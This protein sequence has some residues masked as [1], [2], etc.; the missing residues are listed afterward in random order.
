MF[1]YIDLQRKNWFDFRVHGYEKHRSEKDQRSHQIRSTCGLNG[2]YVLIGGI[3]RLTSG[4]RRDY[5]IHNMI[6]NS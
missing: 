5:E 6:R 1:S 2:R 4:I 3:C